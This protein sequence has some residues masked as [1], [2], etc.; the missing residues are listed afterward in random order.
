MKYAKGSLQVKSK[1]TSGRMNADKPRIN[2]V[3]WTMWAEIFSFTDLAN[4]YP[5]LG[6]PQKSLMV[7]RVK[8]SGCFC[9]QR[10]YSQSKEGSW[11]IFQSQQ[12]GFP[13]A[14]SPAFSPD[15]DCLASRMRSQVTE[16]EHSTA[17]GWR[18]HAK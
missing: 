16:L 11:A 6:G 14:A 4:Q 18:L 2:T 17:W 10:N 7:F 1:R 5:E 15:K 12:G 8:A 9:P 3:V 13:P